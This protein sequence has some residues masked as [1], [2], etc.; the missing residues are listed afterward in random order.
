VLLDLLVHVAHV[1]VGVREDV[2][3][4][5]NDPD[6]RAVLVLLLMQLGP[7]KGPGFRGDLILWNRQEKVLGIGLFVHI[8]GRTL[9]RGRS[10]PSPERV[11]KMRRAILFV[12]LTTCA[13]LTLPEAASAARPKCFGQRA[14]IVG[15]AKAD[16]LNGTSKDDVIVGL[17]KNDTINGRGGDDTICGGD[18]KDTIIGGGGDDW[19]FGEA[20]NDHLKGGGGHDN[21][22][23]GPDN[24]SLDGGASFDYADYFLSSSA[25][26]VNLT[27]GT[28]TGEGTDTLVGIEGLSGSAFDD[29]LT[30]D[31]GENW[32]YPEGGDDVVEGGGSLNDVV[33]FDFSP[34]AVTV[35]LSAGT[36]TGEG[37]DT[38]TGFEAVAGSQHDDIITGD[39][40]PNFFIGWDGDDTIQ[41]GDG[42]DSLWGDAGDDHLDGGLG[43]DAIDGGDG[44]DTC[45]NGEDNTN[46]EA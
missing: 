46:C 41:G 15:T 5:W 9:P 42:D 40:G 36:A 21:L 12:V 18:G 34:S 11:G 45:L 3:Q 2:D 35:D 6:L 33:A 30:G 4:L 8:G 37:T 24:D 23:G 1:V 14:T 17:G 27:T 13:A 22:L 44:T 32:I 25:V 29:T 16:V 39:A 43:T 10:A 31:E 7:L 28:A 19:L 38:L 26:D 20:G